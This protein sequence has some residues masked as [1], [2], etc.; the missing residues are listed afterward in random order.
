MMML[1]SLSIIYLFI[2]HAPMLWF[3]FSFAREARALEKGEHN[4][5]TGYHGSSCNLVN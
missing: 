2:Y 3:P 5:G 1:A 4:M